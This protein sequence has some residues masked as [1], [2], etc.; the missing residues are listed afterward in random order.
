MRTHW[1][2]AVIVLVPSVISA[3]PILTVDNGVWLGDFSVTNATPIDI[4]GDGTLDWKHWGM[5]SDGAT[6]AAGFNSKL[7]GGLRIS[8]ITFGPG[9]IRAAFPN[10]PVAFL[11]TDGTPNDSSAATNGADFAG[12]ATSYA[13]FGMRNATISVES[14][15]TQLRQLKVYVGFGAGSDINNLPGRNL[16]NAQG[17]LRATLGA[18]VVDSPIIDVDTFGT[19]D[20]DNYVF[21]INYQADA[22]GDLSVVWNGFGKYFNAA[23]LSVVPE[24]AT[25]GLIVPAV[26]SLVP[27]LRRRRRA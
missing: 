8:D 5:G 18:T 1:F 13:L 20:G 27:V 11:Y 6:N 3:A 7:T 24:P 17:F 25:T 19:T 12:P 16:D 15:T 14:S 10:N 26:I 23:T 22:V 9:G 2:V 4:T 21:T